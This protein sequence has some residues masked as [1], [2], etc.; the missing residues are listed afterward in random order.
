MCNCD[1]N[2]NEIDP[3]DI[4]MDKEWPVHT[5]VTVEFAEVNGKTKI[6]LYQT[7]SEALA[8]ITGA[9]PSWLQMLDILELQLTQN[10]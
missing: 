8:K 5:Q 3:T 9:Y 4:G 1:E 7:V 6:T 10:K 2:G